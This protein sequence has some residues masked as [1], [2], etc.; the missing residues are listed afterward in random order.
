MCGRRQ[1]KVRILYSSGVEHFASVCGLQNPPRRL[2]RRMVE[3][4]EDIC[5]TLF[6]KETDSTRA[7]LMTEEEKLVAAVQKLEVAPPVSVMPGVTVPLSEEGVLLLQRMCRG[8]VSCVTFSIEKE[9]FTV[10]KSL[11]TAGGDAVPSPSSLVDAAAA[12]IPLEQPRVL[13]L[14]CGGVAPE[15]IVVN[16]CPA[17]SKPRER[18]LYSSCR[19]SFVQQ[20]QHHGVKCVRRM[21]V[22]DMDEFKEAVLEAAEEQRAAGETNVQ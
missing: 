19:A 3:R 8:E 15:A 21:E 10:D 9:T 16:I 7:E 22:S 18:M 12:L 6:L 13:L 2:V 14:R 20:V 1:P 17:S 4:I 5:E 11:E